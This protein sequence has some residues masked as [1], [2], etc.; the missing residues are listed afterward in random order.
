MQTVSVFIYAV[1]LTLTLSWLLFA[2]RKFMYGKETLVHNV[3][4]KHWFK[5]RI[6]SPFHMKYGQGSHSHT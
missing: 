1:I 2:L 6:W 3:C 5:W 4:L